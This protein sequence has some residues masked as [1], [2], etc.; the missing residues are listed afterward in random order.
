MQR[1]FD[2]QPQQAGEFLSIRHRAYFLR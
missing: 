2:M 1:R